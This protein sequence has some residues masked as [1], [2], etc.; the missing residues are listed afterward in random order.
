MNITLETVNAILNKGFVHNASND[1]IIADLNAMN[2]TEADVAE[3]AV[4]KAFTEHGE[5]FHA[6][7]DLKRYMK[8]KRGGAPAKARAP[9]APRAP[10]AP[11]APKEAPKKEEPAM[12]AAEHE[13][14]RRCMNVVNVAG[15]PLLMV[16]PAGSGKSYMAAKVAEAC[17]CTKVYTRSKVAFDTDL[18][19]YMD[20]HSHYCPTALYRAM[21]RADGGEKTAYFLDEIFAGDTSCLIVIND[22]LSDGCMTFPNGEEFSAENLVIIAA[23]NT[24]GCGATNQFNTRNKADASF[25]NRFGSV[26]VDYDKEIEKKLAGEHK[27][28]LDFVYAVRAAAEKAEIDIVCSYRTIKCMRKYAEAGIPAVEAV[29]EFVY[30]NKVTNDDKDT[31]RQDAKITRLIA[32]GNEYAM[33]M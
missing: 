27:D 19:G 31:L 29:E 10:K 21:K 26:F 13:R 22:L 20:A 5:G 32:K 9:R 15:M 6:L 28:I 8:Q 23:D 7:R 2:T 3:Y 16:G 17:G 30:Q 33:A 14:F 25:L 4:S 1:A 11:K 12:G 24:S 18:I